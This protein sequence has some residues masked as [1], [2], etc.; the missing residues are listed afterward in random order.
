MSDLKDFI[1]KDGVLKK[2][3]GQ[4]GDI[5]TPEG[6][7]SIGNYA[8]W[9]CTNLTSVVISNGVKSIGSSSFENC[10][11]LN[12][13]AIP[14]GVISIGD[15]AFSG[16]SNL[17]NVTIPDSV[18]FIGASIISSAFAGCQQLK[19]NE[20]EGLEYLGNDNNPYVVLVRALSRDIESVTIDDNCKLIIK[21]ALS[22]CKN[23]TKVVI[24]FGVRGIGCFAFGHCDSLVTV[25]IPQSVT[26][27]G[28]SAFQWCE[29]L[30]NITLP[31]GL[32]TI[33]E[34][35]FIG[36]SRLEEVIIP[37]GATK[38]GNSAFKHC[39][40]LR[41][42]VIPSTIN[43]IGDSAFDGCDSL[44]CNEK[45]GLDYLGNEHNLYLYLDRVVSKSIA[46][47]TI[48]SECKFIGASVFSDCNDLTSV[49]IPNGVISLGSWAFSKCKNLKS[50][51]IPASLKDIG[52]W[53]F[54]DVE[55]LLIPESVISVIAKKE[56]FFGDN[57]GARYISILR[58][59]KEVLRTVGVFRRM[60]WMQSFDYKEE[61]L[62]PYR[63][64]DILNY[65]TLLAVGNFEGFKI[66]EAWRMRAMILRLQQVEYPISDELK[67]IFI[68][69]LKEKIS[70]LIKIA[71]EEQNAAFI[72]VAIDYGCVT[73]ENKKKVLNA[74]KKSKVD[75]IKELVN[76]L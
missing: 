74:L 54:G 71:E 19:F 53:P 48:N 51:K 61:F 36:C 52:N 18:T 8:F 37:T 10:S 47:V 16:C 29:K 2:Y 11:S 32:T 75:E 39:T 44:V 35:A 55:E 38:I 43:S 34:A 5:V 64:C 46:T 28:D 59:G 56:A 14:E 58:E 66:A 45:E 30:T 26:C 25:E 21:G 31:V 24:P 9:N 72:K 65:D 12:S 20:K 23:L 60:Y 67:E 7:V 70:K 15:S 76:L 3:V 4:G 49:V 69:F 62:A 57:G 42:V 68:E 1:I 33:G 17:T 6:L 73:E 50:L 13:V 22:G 40:G 41:K 27:I 63:E